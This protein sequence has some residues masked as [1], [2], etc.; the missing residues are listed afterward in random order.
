MVYKQD[1]YYMLNKKI[2]ESKIVDIGIRQKI[3]GFF[4]DE[5]LNFIEDNMYK[6]FMYVFL[7]NKFIMFLGDY[8]DSQVVLLFQKIRN[9]LLSI[10]WVY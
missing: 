6:F 1:G 7:K 4:V 10:V 8:I 5:L 9:S 2:I 3:Y